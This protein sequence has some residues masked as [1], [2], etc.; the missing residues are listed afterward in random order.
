MGRF[1]KV[2][3]VTPTQRGVPFK[4]GK[5]RVALAAVK[6]VEGKEGD[7]YYIIE[8]EV[9][10][11]DN[12]EV[13]VGEKRSQVI[14][15]TNKKARDAPF[16]DMKAFICACLGIVGDAHTR[17]T[18]E[19]IEYSAVNNEAMKGGP[20]ETLELDLQVNERPATADKGAFTYHRWYNA[21]EDRAAELLAHFEDLN[22]LNP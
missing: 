2:E 7:I 18:E 21:E 11:T 3:A 17:I 13:R 20:F 22:L 19:A 12:D 4:E 5:Y 1:A 15:T 14:N 6:V 8:A 16:A 10:E 9:K